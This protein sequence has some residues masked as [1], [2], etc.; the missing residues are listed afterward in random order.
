MPR[1]VHFVLATAA[2]ALLSG[3]AQAQPE[4]LRI[5]AIEFFGAAG[6]DTA[7]LRAHLP[8]REGDLVEARRMAQLLEATRA[9]AQ[10]SD[11]A[12]VATASDHF[13]LYIGW[14]DGAFRYRPVPHGKATLPS[15]ALSLAQASWT[16]W[17]EAAATGA[18][19]SIRPAAGLDIRLRDSE[20][21]IRRYAM[22]HAAELRHVL[23]TSAEAPHRA[24]AA[25]FLAYIRLSRRQIRSL[26]EAAYD[27]DEGVRDSAVRALLVLLRTDLRVAAWIQPAGLLAMLHSG[28]WA[29]RH[30]AA[31]L[32]AGLS[33]EQN[34]KLLAGIRAQAW[35][36]LLE[37][38]QWRN[39]DQAAPARQLLG[40]A[41][42]VD[43]PRLQAILRGGDVEALLQAVAPIR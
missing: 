15:E 9:A 3:P 42:G 31:L 33:A 43:E 5:G 10:A 37:M 39:P 35:P 26:A 12:L 32:L 41:G 29:D 40:R 23:Q 16:V 21:A 25:H 30:R 1:F 14:P 8:L 7:A 4:R 27:A 22:R 38:A 17:Q 34:P 36:V 18:S 19:D 2:L 24:T 6:R 28:H 20:T 11:V 13:T